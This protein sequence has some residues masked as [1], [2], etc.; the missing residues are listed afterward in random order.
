VSRFSATP[1]LTLEPTNGARSF[2]TADD[3]W[4]STPLMSLVA[5]STG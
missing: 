1:A 3:G 4:S 2:E 5:P